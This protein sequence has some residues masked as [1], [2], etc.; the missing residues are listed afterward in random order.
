MDVAIRTD[1]PRILKSMDLF[2][3]IHWPVNMVPNG[4]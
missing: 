2:D 1:T 3:A 4:M